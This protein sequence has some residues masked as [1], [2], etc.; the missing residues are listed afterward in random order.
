MIF[1]FNIPLE[2]LNMTK[3][4]YSGSVFSWEG[5]LAWYDT[6]LGAKRA[7]SVR[8]LWNWSGVQKQRNF[9]SRE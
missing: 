7:L 5:G 1:I 6:W 2:Q 8:W 9:F 3:L 4:S